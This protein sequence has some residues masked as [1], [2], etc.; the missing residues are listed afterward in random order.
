[1]SLCL[2][3]NAPNTFIGQHS[4]NLVSVGLDVVDEVDDM[5]VLHVRRVTKVISV[6]LS[7]ASADIVECAGVHLLF[8]AA[9][10]SAVPIQRM[11]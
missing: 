9:L 11:P 10:Q 8:S 7:Q 2:G 4:E 6:P 3:I 1:M 5:V